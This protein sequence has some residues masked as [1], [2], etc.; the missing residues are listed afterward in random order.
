MAMGLRKSGDFC[1][2]NILT[3]KP[4]E[5]MEFFSQVLGWTFFKMPGY[6]HG[7]QVGGRNIGGLFDLHAEGTPPDCP[8]CL[9][10]MVKV[11]S[12]DATSE[13]VLGLG[14]SVKRTFDI[15]E[16]GRMA[17]CLDPTGANIDVWEP[18]Q[19]P[20]SDADSS[21]HGS[22]SWSECMTTD[23][24]RAT[25]FYTNL[26]GWTAEVKAMP[27]MDYTVFRNGGSDI[28][29]LMHVPMESIPSH[30]GTYFTVDET[31]EAVRV[32]TELG[33]TIFV[34]PMDIPGIGRF[35][36]IVSPQGVRFYVIKYLPREVVS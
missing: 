32:A 30:W 22:P 5:A 10:V 6:G 20:G 21:L 31:D 15:G 27:G 11:D 9:G 25:S 33:A 19:M 2:I 26:F 7:M 3:P 34:P 16:Q 4:A 1:W 17:I 12:A 8:P 14:G 24:T 13:K 35:S 29:G 36:G 18:N 23:V 28:A